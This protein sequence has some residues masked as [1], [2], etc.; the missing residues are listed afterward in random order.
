MASKSAAARAAGAVTAR[1][2]GARRVASDTRRFVP[3][4]PRRGFFGGDT[5]AWTWPL[6]SLGASGPPTLRRGLAMIPGDPSPG[7]EEFTPD[8][9][10]PYADNPECF[11]YDE[12]DLESEESM[13]ALYERWRSFY[14]VK[15]DHDEVVRRFVHFK[16][17]A[18]RIHEF[19]KLGKPWSWG[20]QIY[21]DLTPEELDRLKRRQLLR[22]PNEEY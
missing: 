12:K 2:G 10:D 21:G 3:R 16:D 7:P 20:L 9:F 8:M 4:S 6:F 11:D 18:R 1:S 14:N 17:R 19:N 13:R 15:R 5:A 22:R